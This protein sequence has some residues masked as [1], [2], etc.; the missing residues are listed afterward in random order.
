[1]TTGAHAV[2]KISSRAL[3]LA[4]IREDII[5]ISRADTR[6]LITRAIAGGAATIAA[7]KLQDFT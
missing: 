1:M 2:L 3:L 6:M 7:S 5:Y 4:L